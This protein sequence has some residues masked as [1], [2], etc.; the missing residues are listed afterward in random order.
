M[1]PCWDRGKVLTLGLLKGSLDCMHPELLSWG[2]RKEGEGEHRVARLVLVAGG[3]DS[4]SHALLC[5]RCVVNTS[6]VREGAGG[7][8]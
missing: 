8:L 6:R 2:G 5:P 1:P 7:W 4:I 3:G